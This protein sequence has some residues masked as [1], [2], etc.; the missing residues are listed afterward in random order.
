[1]HRAC[2]KQNQIVDRCI[3]HRSFGVRGQRLLLHDEWQGCESNSYQANYFYCELR[4]DVSL[5]HHFHWKLISPH[6]ARERSSCWEKST[7]RVSPLFSGVTA[8]L[9]A[10]TIML[11]V[12]RAPSA[13]VSVMWLIS[14]KM[15]VNEKHPFPLRKFH[16]IANLCATMNAATTFI[17]FIIYGTK[18]RAEFTRIYCCLIRHLRKTKTS[19]LKQMPE[20]EHHQMKE[21]T[22]NDGLERKNST[23]QYMSIPTKAAH[24]LLPTDHRHDDTGTA[25]SAQDSS[26]TTSNTATSISLLLPMKH[27]NHHRKK[28]DVSSSGG[29]S[30][31]THHTS[32]CSQCRSTIGVPPIPHERKDAKSV[33]LNGPHYTWFRNLIRCH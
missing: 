24:Q 13:A 14:A 23:L 29:F 2:S 8:M 3:I 17:M 22:R 30:S 4:R 5:L 15:F 27:A 33:S 12:C 21:L 26:V 28:G 20:L 7:C 25:A 11:L 9:L 16:T 18:F 6:L 32:S 10:T 19:D 1:M 31:T